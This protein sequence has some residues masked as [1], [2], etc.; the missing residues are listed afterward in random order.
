[1]TPLPTK[2]SRGGFFSVGPLT[3]ESRNFHMGLETHVGVARSQHWHLLGATGRVRLVCVAPRCNTY[4][5]KSKRKK[6]KT[7]SLFGV[8]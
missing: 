4:E 5:R 3:P 2:S 7:K 1:L 8:G 6:F